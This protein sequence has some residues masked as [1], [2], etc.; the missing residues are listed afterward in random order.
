MFGIAAAASGTV[1]I[2]WGNGI[3]F[4][5]HRRTRHGTDEPDFRY[6]PDERN[7]SSDTL[8]RPKSLLNQ[9]VR[10][11]EP[12]RWSEKFSE[13]TTPL[14]EPSGKTEFWGFA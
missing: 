14:T 8:C 11:V 3:Y 12:Q 5:S 13:S 10:I 6:P 1:G 9:Y 4:F 2:R 7:D